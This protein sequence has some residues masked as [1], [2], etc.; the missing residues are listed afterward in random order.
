MTCVSLR[1][2]RIIPADGWRTKLTSALVAAA[3]AVAATAA[4]EC[5]GV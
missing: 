2:V 1:L 5:G 4:V 3:A